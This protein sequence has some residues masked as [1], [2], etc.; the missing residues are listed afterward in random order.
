MAAPGLFVL[1]ASTGRSDEVGAGADGFAG[2]SGGRDSTGRVDCD[3]A[4]AC[5]PGVDAAILAG[6]TSGVVAERCAGAPVAPI[7]ATPAGGVRGRAGA[8]ALWVG[9]GA[10]GRTIP[11]IGVGAATVGVFDNGTEGGGAVGRSAGR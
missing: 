4:W 2:G 7:G 1:E 8:L 3:D 9:S 11:S 5:G 10:R 6:S